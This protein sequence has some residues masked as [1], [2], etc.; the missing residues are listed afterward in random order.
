MNRKIV[1]AFALMPAFAI[2]LSY[3][4]SRFPVLPFDSKS[5]EKLQEQASPL[6]DGLMN[7]VS[8][9]GEYH[10]PKVN[11]NVRGG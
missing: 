9:L 10:G 11:P 6:F 7:G 1:R 4:A 3:A 5:Y 8:A 2:M